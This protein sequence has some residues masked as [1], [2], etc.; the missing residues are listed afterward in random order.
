M[1]RLR[2]GH[3]HALAETADD[4]TDMGRMGGDAEELLDEG[5]NTLGGPDFADKAE[6]GGTLG[7]GLTQLVA[8][9]AIQAGHGARGR[10]A[11]QVRHTAILAA[12]D[13]LADRAWGDAQRGSN[14]L[15]FPAL[16]VQ[17]PGTKTSPFAPIDRFL[18]TL[19]HHS[20]SV[21]ETTLEV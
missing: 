11:A 20:A 14:V 18:R 6:G 8:L 15:L 9:V 1:R 13:P 12:F 21:P 2:L 3:L 7:E 17:L 19:F 4:A 5:G 16:L 10:T